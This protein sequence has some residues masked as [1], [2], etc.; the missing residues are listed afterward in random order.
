MI[1]SVGYKDVGDGSVEDCLEDGATKSHDIECATTK[2]VSGDSKGATEG[3]PL[4]VLIDRTL[5]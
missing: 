4:N 1:S 3:N 5:D 2:R